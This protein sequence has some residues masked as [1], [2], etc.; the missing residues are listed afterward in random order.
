VYQRKKAA[1][2]ASWDKSVGAGSQA[3]NSVIQS[4]CQNDGDVMAVGALAVD[5][6]D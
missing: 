1:I 4:P 6:F 2:G 3:P 5:F